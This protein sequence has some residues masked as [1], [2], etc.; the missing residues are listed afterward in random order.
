MMLRL[1]AR[2]S[3]LA[4]WQA[5]HVQSL[6]Q[7]AHPGLAVEVVS[8]RTTGD[9]TTDVPLARMGETGLFTKEIDRAVLAGRVDAAVHSLK[10]LPTGSEPG[11]A[12]AAVLRREDPRDALIPAPGRP[13]TLAALPRGARV[14]TSSLRRRAQLLHARPDLLVLDLRG[15]LDTRL[16]QLSSGEYDAVILAV[17][18]LRRLGR[19][20]AIG[21]ILEAPAWLPAAGQGALAVTAREDDAVTRDLLA[22]LDDA[23]TRAEVT[24]ERAF[25]RGL[26]GGCQIPI[27][28]LADVRTDTLELHGF[29]A[30]LDG[31][32]MLA[33]EARG[34]AG[35]AEGVG[36]RLARDLLERGAARLLR[37]LRACDAA[38]LPQVSAP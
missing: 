32:R 22:S 10:D 33:G 25:L 19:E 1:G 23:A 21:E 24:A 14:G 6:L 37:E 16:R 36:A 18:G 26:E 31:Q 5:E 4:R 3:A 27:G 35:E 9:R 30:S 2:G 34:S 13:A 38:A 7:Q 17:A 29:I 12:L 20:A 11:L 8:L 15:N 28:A